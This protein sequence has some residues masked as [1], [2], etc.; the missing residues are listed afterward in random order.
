MIVHFPIALIVVGFLFELFYLFYKKEPC[1]TKVGFLLMIVGTLGA[2]SAF[3]TGEFFTTEL[4][5]SAGEIQETHEL[6]AIITMVVMSIATLL[7]VMLMVKNNETIYL[8]WV[9]FALY[10]LGAISVGIT[11][12]FGGSLVYNYLIGL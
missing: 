12:F 7:R 9:V 11:G 8:K 6:F 3:L 10:A 1:I 5:G 2:I 4:T